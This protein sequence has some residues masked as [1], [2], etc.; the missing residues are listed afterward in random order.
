MVS[1]HCGIRVIQGKV[2][3]GLVIKIGCPSVTDNQKTNHFIF[4][5][6]FFQHEKISFNFWNFGIIKVAKSKLNHLGFYCK[7]YFFDRKVRKIRNRN[8]NWVLIDGTPCR[9]GLWGS[10]FCTS[11]TF[12]PVKKGQC[13]S[14]SAP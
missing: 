6:N 7:L 8:R 9:S 10:R 4:F 11:Y 1:L 14:F 5:G 3:Q 13:W 12:L 2:D